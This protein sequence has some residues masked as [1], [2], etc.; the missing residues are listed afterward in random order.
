[1]SPPLDDSIAGTGTG[2]LQAPCTPALADTLH[3]PRS[4]LHGAARHA[5]AT[6]AVPACDAT[7]VWGGI[8]SAMPC[9]ICGSMIVPEGPEI[10]VEFPRTADARPN[11]WHFHV[12][13]FA[14]WDWERRHIV[15]A[16]E[17][18]VSRVARRPSPFGDRSSAPPASGTMAHRERLTPHNRSGES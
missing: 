14:A 17:D 5:L 7:K 13:C 2:P 11:G 18:A 8:G 1:M 6:R 12:A 16:A 15:G 4:P 9:A 3:R 10:E